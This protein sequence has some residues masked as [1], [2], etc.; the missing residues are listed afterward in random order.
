MDDRE[1][2]T[3]RLVGLAVHGL[4]FVWLVV[5]LAGVGISLYPGALAFVVGGC[6]GWGMVLMAA[7]ETEERL[8]AQQAHAAYLE[9]SGFSSKFD[10][11][12]EHVITPPPGAVRPDGL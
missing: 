7:K 6:W 11:E 4:G 12:P 3:I 9:R 8:R 1:R 10:D 2:K 5:A